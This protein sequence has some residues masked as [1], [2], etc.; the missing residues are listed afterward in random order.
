MTAQMDHVRFGPNIGS[1]GAAQ[2][3]NDVAKLDGK[4]P[5]GA[6]GALPVPF[7]TLAIR[8]TDAS[9]AFILVRKGKGHGDRE[10]RFERHRR[11]GAHQLLRP[12]VCRF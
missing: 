8:S 7:A 12:N 3:A 4:L 1:G 9:G 11:H 6:A 5:C 2:Y 10:E